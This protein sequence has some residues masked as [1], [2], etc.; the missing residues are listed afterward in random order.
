MEVNQSEPLCLP[1][2]NL[3]KSQWLSAIRSALKHHCL[4]SNFAVFL[5]VDSKR[6]K[7]ESVLALQELWTYWGKV[8]DKCEHAG[9]K[10]E[11]GS[12]T[13][14]ACDFLHDGQLGQSIQ[15]E[16]T[17]GPQQ[18]DTEVTEHMEGTTPI[19]HTCM[20]RTQMMGSSAW[21]YQ[22]SW[23][24]LAVLGIQE[25]FNTWDGQNIKDFSGY[26]M[27]NEF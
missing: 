13:N 8:N 27:G 20:G 16:R 9:P 7:R 12:N 17:I 4:D 21:S 2:Y 23:T 11:D 14:E 10:T 19:L 1:I 22:G 26:S 3:D 15:T 24:F 5:N 6:Y 18:K 25:Q